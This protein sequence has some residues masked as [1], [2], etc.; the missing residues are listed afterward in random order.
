[1]WSESDVNIAVSDVCRQKV[2]PSLI[3]YGD[4]EGGDVWGVSRDG[5]FW[6]VTDVH[7]IIWNLIVCI[8]SENSKQHF[9]GSL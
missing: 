3:W 7:T 5:V 1:M 8:A 4:W 9:E 6:V 2:V